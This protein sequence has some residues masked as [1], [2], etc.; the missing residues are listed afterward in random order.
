MRTHFLDRVRE[1]C[2]EVAGRAKYVRIDRD[3]IAD[4]AASISDEELRLPELDPDYHYLGHGEDTAAYVVTLATINFG[5]GYFPALKKSVESSGYFTIARALKE[6][7]EQRGPLTVDELARMDA[8]DCARI[9]GQ[10]RRDKT[11]RELMKQYA[12]SLSELGRHLL[13]RYHASFYELLQ[14][15]EGSAERLAERLATM[16]RFDD[17]AF[18][19]DLDVAFYKRAQL[20]AADLSLAFGGEGLGD[21]EDLES[22]TLFA[23]NQVPHVLRVDGILRYDSPLARHVDAKGPIPAQSTEEV[24]IRACAVHAG[25]LIVAEMRGAGRE[26]T[27]AALDYCLWNRGL[28]SRYRAQPAHLT[29]TIFY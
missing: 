1:V 5:S 11:V 15:A 18:Y 3:R 27:A 6:R 7:F 21:L 13:E 2:Q 9:F 24:E 10:R 12:M 14:S 4:Y 23:D 16:S 8:D 19:G 22:L 28:G 26:V 17:V 29:K 25:E 20:G